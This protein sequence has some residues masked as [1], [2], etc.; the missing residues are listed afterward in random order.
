MLG[1]KNNRTPI[2]GKFAKAVKT[3]LN[4]K[5]L[6]DG[7]LVIDVTAVESEQISYVDNI[8]KPID[9]SEKQFEVLMKHIEEEMYKLTAV[10]TEVTS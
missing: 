6:E 9:M 3:K 4:E 2:K 10:P 5:E 8:I 1:M 7:K